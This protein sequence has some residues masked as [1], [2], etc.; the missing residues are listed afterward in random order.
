[1]RWYHVVAALLFAAGLMALAVPF[2]GQEAGDLTLATTRLGVSPEVADA[3]LGL[4][5]LFSALLSAVLVALAL[6]SLPVGV[7]LSLAATIP[8]MT[9]S[10]LRLVNTNFSSFHW[11]LLAFATV[12]VR[13]KA[14]LARAPGA[15]PALA[16]AAYCVAQIPRG[17]DLYDAVTTCLS[18][19]AMLLALYVIV[20]RLTAEQFRSSML[21]GVVGSA[22]VCALVLAHG[23]QADDID[24][25]GG[26]WFLNPNA[27]GHAVVLPLL[28][29]L[30][31]ILAK[32]GS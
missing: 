26:S 14:R 2:L 6:V 8:I 21:I 4:P 5:M 31:D 9:L 12:V 29:Y 28:F 1:M 27:L 7:G 19:V 3:R 15:L 23:I 25:L 16:Y 32:R 10:N 18:V 22:A 30:E 24:R 11:V 20:P 13:R 17:Y